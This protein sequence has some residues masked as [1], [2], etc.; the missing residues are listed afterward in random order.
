MPHCY[1]S[2]TVFN[3]TQRHYCQISTQM[4]R[5]AHTSSTLNTQAQNFSS[6][7]QEKLWQG[8]F[9]F[10]V[11]VHQMLLILRGRL[12]FW[13]NPTESNHMEAILLVLDAQSTQH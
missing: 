8:N 12:P 10:G 6:R 2:C 1:N 4:L 7:S 3:L 11:L 13:H 9:K 5:F